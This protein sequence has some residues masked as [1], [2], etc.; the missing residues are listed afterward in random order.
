MKKLI[1]Y[2]YAALQYETPESARADTYMDTA[3]GH[4]P[5]PLVFAENPFKQQVLDAKTVLDIGCGVGRNLR[6][7][8]ENTNA[9]Y[10]AVEPNPHMA[11][12]FWHY[13]D[14]KWQDRVAVFPDF[15]SIPQ[16]VIFDVVEC[17]FVLQHL[18]YRAAEGQMNVSDITL[19]AMKH[20]TPETV[21]ILIEHQHEEA[22][23]DRWKQETGLQIALHIPDYTGIPELTHRGTHDLIIAKG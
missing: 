20:T 8:M 15:E 1:P 22:W 6:W 4:P 3:G 12:W 7:V 13:Q 23:M 16:N 9:N 11:K 21:W 19:A 10:I 5:T 17:T 18:G 2:G 14:A